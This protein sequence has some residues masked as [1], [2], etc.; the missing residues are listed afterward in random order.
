MPS[1]V[2][3]YRSSSNPVKAFGVNID[4]FLEE[5]FVLL[6]SFSIFTKNFSIE[7]WLE[8]SQIAL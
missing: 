2:G 6:Y 4:E 1:V 3:L 5:G 7:A 8:L